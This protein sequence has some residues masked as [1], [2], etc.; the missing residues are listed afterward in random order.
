MVP[1]KMEVGENCMGRTVHPIVGEP[2]R[3]LIYQG[4]WEMDEKGS[5]SGASLSEGNLE[6]G[7]F[8]GDP[9]GCVK[10]GSGDSH[11]SP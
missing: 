5:R 10:E 1:K 11:L 3:G 6:G 7:L 8:T 4:L 2:G 9:G